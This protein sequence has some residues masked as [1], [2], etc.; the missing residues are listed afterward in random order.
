MTRW[1]KALVKLWDR[2]RVHCGPDMSSAYR[3]LLAFYDN[4]ELLSFESGTRSGSWI[5]PEA[6][7]VDTGRLT[8]PDGSVLADWNVHPLH[9][10]T[11][12]P[13]FEGTLTRDELDSH[14]FSVPEHPDRIPFHFRNQYRH[15]AP[16]W[17]FC[18]PHNVRE[19]LPPGQYKVEI[20]TKFEP[21]QM[22]MVEQVHEGDSE[23]SVLLVGH[24]DHPYMC[25]DGLTGCLAGHE[26]ISNLKGHDTKLTYRMLST[27]E[28]VGSV[29]YADFCAKKRN[30]KEALFVASSGADA[31]IA[32]QTSFSGH[33]VVDRV[34]RHILNTTAS[35]WSEHPFRLGPLGNDET[36][37]DVGGVDIPCGSIM[38]APFATYHTDADNPE[39]VNEQRFNQ[40]VEILGRVI[41]VLERNSTLTRRFAGLPCLS[42]PDLDLYL[43]PPQMSQVRQ[44]TMSDKFFAGLP[45]GV[46]D[47]VEQRSDR[48]NY[49]MNILPIMCD[50]G[51]TT[52]NVAEKTGLPFEVVDLYGDLWRS[53]D[54][55]EKEWVNPFRTP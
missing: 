29:F 5:A 21:G 41:N 26:V 33:S 13:S 49:M 2:N 38:R 51:S 10:Y 31:P 19:N 39:S 20:S 11:F 45:D 3:D 34:M 52:L 30:V 55:I 35:E 14:L 18:L 7:S 16:E 40:I 32:Y 15:W 36:A 48:L 17:G 50:G 9:L 12:S 54:L 47:V 23:D 53:K 25:N 24:F 43:S 22:E 8:G 44:I 4:C 42:S 6:W 1:Q 46:R 37:F 27:V 28:I